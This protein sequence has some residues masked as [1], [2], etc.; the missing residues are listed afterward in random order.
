[1][2][3]SPPVSGSTRTLKG[4]CFCTLAHRIF[5]FCL[6]CPA[7]SRDDDARCP[8]TDPLRHTRARCGTKQRRGL[9]T[10]HTRSYCTYCRRAPSPCARYKHPTAVLRIP[11]LLRNLHC[12]IASPSPASKCLPPLTCLETLRC[13]L[14]PL[15]RL[16]RNLCPCMPGQIRTRPGTSACMTFLGAP[17]IIGTVL[18][19]CQDPTEGCA[20]CCARRRH[21][22]NDAPRWLV[23]C[24]VHARQSAAAIILRAFVVQKRAGNVC[25]HQNRGVQRALRPRHPYL[26]RLLHR[27]CAIS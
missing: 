3:V 27:P 22:Q 17:S 16:H 15:R 26:P 14:L 4:T 6:G 13:L 19:C 11:L 7:P 8:R 25:I 1:M 23:S 24:V 10:P 21:R 2:I 9:Y 18:G 12:T 20:S 5:G